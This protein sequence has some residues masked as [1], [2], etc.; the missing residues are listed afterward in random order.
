MSDAPDPGAIVG[1]AAAAELLGCSKI[2]VRR[3]VAEGRL[4][5]ALDG[6]GR[7][8][9]RRQE[10]EAL[11][12]APGRA[13]TPRRAAAVGGRTREA[14]VAA[15]NEGAL[16][17]AVFADLEAGRPLVQIVIDHRLSADLAEE[18]AR[19]WRQW[20]EAAAPSPSAPAVALPPP[21]GPDPLEALRQTVAA[22]QRRVHELE[23]NDDALAACL[24]QLPLR[25][26]TEFR[27]AA[28][29]ATG[30]LAVRVT[31]TACGQ[32][33]ATGFY[34]AEKTEG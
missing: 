5:A 7:H 3:L 11:R 17:A 1:W 23:E 2:Q 24:A 12:T 6:Q 10:L 26:A 34:P 18:L 21:P 28:C 27:C 32:E 20:K 15:R 19:R 25:T 22:L 4:A 33:T 30:L 8:C 31:C 29:G 14:S 9:F 13:H 16:H